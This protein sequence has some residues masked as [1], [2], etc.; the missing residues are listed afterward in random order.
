VL[1]AF[2]RSETSTAV[3][4]PSG[5]YPPLPS[6]TP[7]CCFQQFL[8]IELIFVRGKRELHHCIQSSCLPPLDRSPC[9]T[10][11]RRPKLAMLNTRLADDTHDNSGWGH[12]MPPVSCAKLR[13]S[14]LRSISAL[15]CTCAVFPGFTCQS[16]GKAA[17]SPGFVC[18][19][20]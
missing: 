5:V 14:L 1:H 8:Q 6:V 12:S 3:R 11:N 10:P 2:K 20:A 15:Y 16:K 9:S 17:S 4:G 19:L 13:S 18:R 7:S